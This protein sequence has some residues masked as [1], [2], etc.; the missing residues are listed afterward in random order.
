M[1]VDL[2][3]T[4]GSPAECAITEVGAVKVRGGEV[5]GEFQ[6]LVNPG[7]PIP[8][9]IQVLTGI[10]DSMVASA[11]PIEQRPA[12]LPRVRPWQRPGRAQRRLRHQLPA[13]GRR[14]DRRAVARVPGDRHRAPWPASWSAT[15]RCTTAGS[16]LWPAHFGASTTP[17]HRA[18][19]DARATVDVLH[20]LLGR[21]GNLGVRT[22]EELASYTSRVTP[23][24]RR[25]RFLADG[26]PTAP[27]VYVFQDRRGRALYVGTSR[28]IRARVRSYFTSAEQRTRMAEMV[29]HRRAH[30]ADRL[31][32]RRSRRRCASC[33]SSPSTSR[34][35]NRR[36]DSP[37]G[38]PVGQAHRRA[39]PAALDRP[40]GPRRRRP[41]CRPVLL[42]G[43]CR[44]GRRGRPRGA[45]ATP[46][47]CADALPRASASACMLA[48]LGRCG[49]PCVGAA[50]VAGVRRGCRRRRG[51]VLR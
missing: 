37:G 7:A 35:Y 45:A 33:A 31:R 15:T 30:P 40:R 23:A 28:N 50:D 11:P 51:A 22:L 27:G 12:R 13:G 14:R 25:K 1:V 20:A 18:L 6:T 38:G 21:V 19:H 2:E 3:T 46:V 43:G 24:Q 36:S 8:A 48:E 10:T 32:R 41:V 26:L 49:A 4:G 39:V 47:H 16:A 42:A 9:F 17:D 44:G 29:R 34:R 5:L